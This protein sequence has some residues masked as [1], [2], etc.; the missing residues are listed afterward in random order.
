MT[1]SFNVL[2]RINQKALSSQVV[3]VFADVFRNGGAHIGQQRTK[4]KSRHV[5]NIDINCHCH[6]LVSCSSALRLNIKVG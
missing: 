5:V 6:R 3:D 1:A 2:S 4:S